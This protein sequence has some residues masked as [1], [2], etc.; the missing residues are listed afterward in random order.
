[1]AF[2]IPVSR[3]LKCYTI[4]LTPARMTNSQPRLRQPGQ[5]R[6]LVLRSKPVI[7]GHCRGPRRPIG[8]FT[9]RHLA[10]LGTSQNLNNALRSG[11]FSGCHVVQTGQILPRSAHQWR[12]ALYTKDHVG[13]QTTRICIPARARNTGRCNLDAR[14]QMP[15]VLGSCQIWEVSNFHIR[16]CVVQKAAF[17]NSD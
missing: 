8:K 9:S 11:C 3:D 10:C 15:V 2:Q 13:Y 6:L 14:C 17:R 5:V 4:P 12:V 1:M 16:M 7:L